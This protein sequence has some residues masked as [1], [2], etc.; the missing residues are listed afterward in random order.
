[1]CHIRLPPYGNYETTFGDNLVY[2]RMQRV[3]S[4]IAKLWAFSSL[5]ATRKLHVG[6]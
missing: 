6:T 2:L 1:V 4:G 5:T 3:E